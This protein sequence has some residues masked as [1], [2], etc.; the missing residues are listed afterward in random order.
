[1]GGRER[2]VPGERLEAEW[3]RSWW[4]QADAALTRLM[5]SFL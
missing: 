5:Q 4:E 1:G 2:D 3:I